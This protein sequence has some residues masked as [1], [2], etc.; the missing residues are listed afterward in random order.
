MEKLLKLMGRL[1]CALAIAL[2]LLGG[3]LAWLTFRD[4]IN[5]PCSGCQVEQRDAAYP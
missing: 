4:W 1:E 3:Q 2:M 5:H